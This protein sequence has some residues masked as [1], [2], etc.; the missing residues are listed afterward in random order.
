MEAA[1]LPWCGMAVLTA[2]C[3]SFKSDFPWLVSF[4]KEWTLPLAAYVN[5]VTDAVVSL[6]Q[7][8]FRT[9]SALLD[10]P[11]RDVRLVLAWLPWPAV[12]LAVAALALKASGERLAIF[13]VVALAY[14]LLAGYWQQSMNT[15]AL[16]LLAVPISMT[17]DSFSG[18]LAVPGRA[19][20]RLCSSG[21]T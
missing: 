18:C 21:S 11:M 5:A 16:V 7:P 10:L 1:L 14:I 6:V 17:V 15:L 2:L 4:P 3:L 8:G 19:F 12:M 9:L 13:A 20:A